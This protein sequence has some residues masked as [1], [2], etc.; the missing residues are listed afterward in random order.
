MIAV[1][2][3]GVAANCPASNAYRWVDAQ[4]MVHFSDQ[5]PQNAAAALAKVTV[6][7][8]R[9]E[10][11]AVARLRVDQVGDHYDAVVTNTL[12]GPLEVELNA[13]RTNNFTAAPF[14]PSR[15]L[16]GP[17]ASATLS[18]LSPINTSHNGGFQLEL[19]AV[20]G[21][22]NANPQSVTYLLP[23]D[24]NAWHI[25]Q[26]WHGNFSHN[27]AQSG[28][29]IDINV[30]EGTPVL[31]ARAGVVMQV[32]SD[33]NM[34]G[35]NREKYVERANV[36]RIVHDDGTMAIYAHL[37]IDGALVRPGERVSAGQRIGYSG[38]TGYSSGPHL[39]FAVLVNRG[40]DLESIPFRMQGP[41]GPVSIP[42][43]R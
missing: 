38:N 15:A 36:I 7:P 43:A 34:A 37:K 25:D 2:A 40:M 1:A 5:P 31:A 27:D 3:L 21:D 12:A 30:G 4:G 10:V 11:A 39:H 35:L 23:V 22:P 16:L 41:A 29:A 28:Y 17:Y 19:S 32:E 42:G 13:P 26:G 33:F 9:A 20:P 8:M 14:L 18:T 24:T 6:I